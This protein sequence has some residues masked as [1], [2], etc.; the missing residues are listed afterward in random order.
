MN[1]PALAVVP[2]VLALARC[3]GPSPARDA[4]T[5]AGDTPSPAVRIEL[6]TGQLGW[7]PLAPAGTAVE[8]IHGPQGGYHLFGRV[9]FDTLGPDVYI[10]FR[11]T[12]AEGGAA[13]NDPN[14]RIRLTEGRGLLRTSA[15]WETSSAQL[16]IL[17]TVSAP[18]TVVGRR[19]RL[20][21]TV[22]ASPGIE[23]SPAASVTREIVVV[24]ET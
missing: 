1:R 12:P 22:T 20:E 23:T 11:V 3:A 18:A 10:R 7:E 9:R 4:A 6:G 24:D 16:V 13:V 8:L 2:L 5:D 15:G 17:V 14:D 21:A 19:F